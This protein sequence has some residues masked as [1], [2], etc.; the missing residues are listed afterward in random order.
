MAYEYFFPCILGTKDSGRFLTLC[1]RPVAGGPS[2]VVPTVSLIVVVGPTG[3]SSMA[4]SI[5]SPFPSSPTSHSSTTYYIIFNVWIHSCDVIGNI[6]VWHLLLRI[7]LLIFYILFVSNCIIIKFLDRLG[8]ATH[9][10][11]SPMTSPCRLYHVKC[12]GSFAPSC[13]TRARTSAVTGITLYCD[14]R[15]N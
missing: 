2:T 7:T 12:R 14:R 5:T 1:G 10:G 4:C 3:A 6:Q 15:I 8:L 13:S 9:A 11:L